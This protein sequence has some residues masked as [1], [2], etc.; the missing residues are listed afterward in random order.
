MTVTDPNR[1]HAPYI[2]LSTALSMAGTD[3]LELAGA[4]T[5]RGGASNFS[6]DRAANAARKA[7]AAV[8]EYYKVIDAARL[9][10]TTCPKCGATAA[11]FICSTP[12]CPV[13]GGAAYEPES[14]TP[15]SVAIEALQGH[16]TAR[17]VP[18]LRDDNPDE[19][20]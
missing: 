14:R 18:C 20:A 10:L 19:A 2:H 4:V 13:N 17:T 5:E 1:D 8:D 12:G 16:E 15:L 9:P 3:L 7:L 11:A 6:L